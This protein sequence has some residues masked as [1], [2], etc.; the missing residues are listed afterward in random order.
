MIRWIKAEINS[1][2]IKVKKSYPYNIKE[3]FKS[4]YIEYLKEDEDYYYGS[5]DKKAYN[6]NRL[7]TN[8]W[9]IME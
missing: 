8:I 6:I 2:I 9:F 3:L 5:F 4:Y 1:I 7:R